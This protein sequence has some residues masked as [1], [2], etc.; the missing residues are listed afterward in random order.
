VNAATQAHILRVIATIDENPQAWTIYSG[1]VARY[2]DDAWHTIQYE[3]DAV[4]RLKG[5]GVRRGTGRGQQMTFRSRLWAARPHACELCGAP[6]TWRTCDAAHKIAVVDG[7]SYADDNG[8]L[9]CPSCHRGMDSAKMDDA[10]DGDVSELAD[11]IRG[12]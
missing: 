8:L 9:L 7:G 6:L 11:G 10:P 5:T 4:A 2:V 1:D 3:Q 12:A